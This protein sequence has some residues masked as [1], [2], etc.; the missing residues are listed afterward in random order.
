MKPRSNKGFAAREVVIVVAVIGLL[1]ALAI[2]AFR[3]V[4]H[5]SQDKAVRCG[6]RQL[7]AAADQYFLENGA[8]SVAYRNLVHPTNYVKAVSRRC[9]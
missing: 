1:A 6:I 7:A 5:S 4:R 2:P 8:S 9:G 3:M